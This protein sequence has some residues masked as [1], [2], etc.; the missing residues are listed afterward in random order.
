MDVSQAFDVGFPYPGYAAE[1]GYPLRGEILGHGFMGKWCTPP[2]EREPTKKARR[3]TF[4]DSSLLLDGAMRTRGV[5][6]DKEGLADMNEVHDTFFRLGA[7][8]GT[9]ERVRGAARGS[10]RWSLRARRGR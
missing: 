6:T 4:G 9:D 3:R 1:G 2:W 5:L 10:D 7:L 8:H